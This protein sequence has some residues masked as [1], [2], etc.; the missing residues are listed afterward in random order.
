[1]IYKILD[2]FSGDYWSKIKQYGIQNNLNL[3]EQMYDNYQCKKFEDNDGDGTIDT[4]IDERDYY[5]GIV[6]L[7]QKPI[8]SKHIWNVDPPADP[9][10]PTQMEIDYKNYYNNYNTTF[11]ANLENGIVL[12]THGNIPL[13][14]K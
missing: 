5:Q 7:P 9:S 8:K 11:Y 14:A 1:M 10:S 3:G 12:N 13:S 6:R 2:I 4:T